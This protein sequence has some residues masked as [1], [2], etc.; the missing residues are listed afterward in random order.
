MFQM[1]NFK[2]IFLFLIITLFLGC[3][4]NLKDSRIKKEF[5]LSSDY[6]R[7]LSSQY[8]LKVGDNHI[9][10]KIISKSCYRNLPT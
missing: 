1:K 2:L 9:T 3:A 10:S 4:S 8:S 6:G 5:E 7:F